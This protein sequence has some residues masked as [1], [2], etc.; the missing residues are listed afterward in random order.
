MKGSGGSG[1]LEPVQVNFKRYACKWQKGRILPGNADLV[2]TG[3]G[4][5][6]EPGYCPSNDKDRPK[7]D[8]PGQQSGAPE[9]AIGNPIS[10]QTSTKEQLETDYATEDGL[11][12]VDRQ[13]LSRLRGPVPQSLTE[14]SG[15]GQNWLG[16]LPG[17][18]TIAGADAQIAEYL[19]VSGSV[20]VFKVAA[21]TNLQDYAYQNQGKSRIK[22][23]V[24]G[25]PGPDRKDYMY[26]QAEITGGTAEFR[27]DFPNGDYI[28][29]R[30]MGTVTPI[31][32]NRYAVPIERGWAS[33]YK[34]FFDYNAGSESPY[35]IRDSFNRQLTVNWIATNSD[36]GR[37][38]RSEKAVDGIGLPD[39]TSLK[40]DYDNGGTYLPPGS[41]TVVKDRL[42]SVKRL[43]ATNSILWQRSYL[44][45]RTDF[46]YALT[47]IV[48]GAG[49]RLATYGYSAAGVANSTEHAGG[50]DKWQ[51]NAEVV[52]TNFRRTVTNPLGRQSVYEFA[53]PTASEPYKPAPLKTVTGSAIGS[54]LADSRQ[55]TY[56]SDL[57][58][59]TL[60][61][62]GNVTNI[63]NDT[64]NGRPTSVI[65]GV[66]TAQQRAT[67]ITWHPTFD[68][69]TRE[70]RPG[71]QIDYGY[72]AQGRLISR[73]E[74]D[75]TTQT[76]PYSTNGQSRTT[77]YSWTN[78]GRLSSVNGPMPVNGLGQDDITS[79]AY[80]SSG[81][82]MT[83]TNA[84]GQV[85]TFQNYDANGRPAQ[86]VDPNLV[87]TAFTY[88]ALGR[89]QTINRKNAAN[90][91]LDATTTIE[92]DAEGRVTGIIA[93]LTEKMT[94]TYSLA[95]R[96]LS[97][98]APNGEK[99]EYGYDALGDITSQTVKRANGSDASSITRTFDALGRMLSET[100]GAGRTSTFA[101][102]KNDNPVSMTSP[103]G[104][105]TIASFDALD[106]LVSTVAP[107]SATATNAYNAFDDAVS[108]TD[109]VSVT[110]G[111]VRN[112]FGEVIR[113]TSPDRG[114]SVYYYDAAG[115]LTA[116]IDGRGTRIDYSYDI[117]GRVTAKSPQG[118]PAQE[119][120]YGY[121][122][123]TNGVGHLTSVT[124]ATG[125]TS[126]SYDH[127]GNLL[128]KT[129]SVGSSNATLGY[130]YDLAD[131]IVSI[132]Y[133]S[134]RIV[135]YVR[136][137]R[138]RVAQITTRENAGG[139]PVSLLTLATYESF[140][141]L[142]T[143][144]FGNGTALLQDWGNDGLL[145][146]KRLYRTGNNSNLSLLNYSYDLDDN[147]LGI[148]DGVP[149]CSNCTLAF[150]KADCA[151]S[152]SPN[153]SATS[154]KPLA[155]CAFPS[156][157]PISS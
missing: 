89:A 27:I 90:P 3:G 64:A 32:S 44:Y 70:E 14:P 50:V 126:F 111:F 88:D 97:V 45:E 86:V 115:E 151:P 34:Q 105:V 24:L 113:E 8:C 148:T 122:A 12:R 154:P 136:D 143:A 31:Y 149:I 5:P 17:R 145:A 60:D 91:S 38:G 120:A 47:G 99:I 141:S 121:D 83:I 54:V 74:T 104:N 124:D 58:T 157:F 103:R 18:L 73:T 72:D 35:Q 94:M 129:Q 152:M 155:H 33:G 87:V 138:G 130:V 43:S 22:L 133:P 144:A 52:G 20:H 127:R 51:V 7:C 107:G 28:L 92:Y 117:L 13:Y 61:A 78:E 134:G 25:T 6:V 11:L 62:K 96:L 42:V 46:P 125:I 140:G 100:L 36:D 108:F 29:F 56:T 93:P 40:Y 75:T 37:L 21:P 49:N 67:V 59:S 53:I 48:D 137:A 146:Q 98:S 81:N 76:L 102:D 110:T 16:I 156:L 123:G 132:A 19:P 80:D 26:T 65:E 41:T 82:L 85:T 142:T 147:I 101:Y 139:N 66:S 63:V 15:F 150:S 30:R 79:F 69:P 119:I 95:G 57:V 128:S 106:R 1:F 55:F 116:S 118:S 23:T 112:G 10:L 71:L 131:R 135:D 114:S 2:C 68:L 4:T 109:P 84:L 39:G 9:M 153:A 77:A